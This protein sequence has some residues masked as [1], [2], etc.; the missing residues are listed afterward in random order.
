MRM[1]FGGLVVGLIGTEFDEMSAV[2]DVRMSWIDEA[3]PETMISMTVSSF[4]MMSSNLQAPSTTQRTKRQRMLTRCCSSRGSSMVEKTMGGT[5]LRKL[6]GI[7]V[8]ILHFLSWY[9]GKN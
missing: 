3:I 9:I 1:L 2:I 4:K 6:E 5:L 7:L 8:L